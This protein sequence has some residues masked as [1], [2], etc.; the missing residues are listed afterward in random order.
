MSKTL[1][2]VEAYLEKVESILA[3]IRETQAPAIDRAGE[4]MA[5]AIAKGRAVF[6]FG[7]GHSAIPVLDV[8]PRYGSFVGFYPLTDPRLMWFTPVGPGGARELLWL[9]R[10]E[11]YIAN[12][13]KS[14]PLGAGDVTLVFSHGG[15][16]AA[17]VET[18]LAAKERGS[19]V[20]AVTSMTN[21][22]THAPTHSSGKRLADVADVAIDNCTSPEDAQVTIQGWQHPVAA[23]ST[24]AF[25]AI[26]Q[27]LVAAT[28]QHLAFSGIRKRVFVSPNV[29]DV[30][31]GNNE[32]VFEEYEAWIR[33]L[34]R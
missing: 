24:V 27:A 15:L 4:M 30:E 23:A 8:F 21:A 25:V 11:G 19:A 33:T 16:N 14:H 17:P 2:P 7:S 20:V 22:R 1:A 10:E 5:G 13:L 29:K 12:F 34:A 9:E 28:A 26:A 31:P 6:V 3:R 18:A 32:R